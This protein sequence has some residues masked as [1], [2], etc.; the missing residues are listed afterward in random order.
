MKLAQCVLPVLLGVRAVPAAADVLTDFFPPETKVVFGIRVHNLTIS[1]LAQ[2]F[3]AQAQAASAGWLKTVSMTGFD[4]LRD[5]DEVMIASSGEGQNPPA[6]MVVTG[7]FDVARLAE[8]AR[9]YHDVPM[10]GGTKDTDNVVALLDGSTAIAG[11]PALVRAAIDGRDGKAKIDTALNDRITS[12]RQ[13][14]DIWGLGERPEGF[15]APTPEA[16]GLESIDRFQF[17]MQLAGGLEL[18]AEIHARS[19]QDAEKLNTSLQLVAAMLKAQQPSGAS[20]FDLQAEDGTIK[21]TVSIP[22]EELKKTIQAETAAFTQAATPVTA[23]A[24][25]AATPESAVAAPSAPEVT[26]DPALTEPPVVPPAPPKEVPNAAPKAA[27]SQVVDKEGNTVILRL[28]GK[29]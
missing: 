12:L 27:T 6:L 10:L 13:R 26:P 1:S 24:V 20:R 16:K 23:A 11:D 29:K 5:I 14:Y 2:S 17:G 25:P 3:S 18:A 22:E 4:A 19:A 7:R 15:T 9:R 21:L 28:P 8:G